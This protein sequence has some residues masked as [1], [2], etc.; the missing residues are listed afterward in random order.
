MQRQAPGSANSSSTV[1][2]LES[3]RRACASSSARR[4][5]AFGSLASNGRSSWGS[6]RLFSFFRL[7]AEPS[8]AAA[9]PR[10]APCGYRFGLTERTRPSV[11]MTMESA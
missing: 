9:F 11:N 5:V 1:E 4:V 3:P 7:N 6:I 10:Q 8:P 2:K